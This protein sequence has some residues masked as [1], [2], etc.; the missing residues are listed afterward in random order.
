MGRL[1]CFATNA[2][3]VI[4]VHVLSHRSRRF[5]LANGFAIVVRTLMWIRMI[6][7]AVQIMILVPPMYLTS[8]ILEEQD[9]RDE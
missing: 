1:C 7:P 6:L 4:I 9:V 2:M 3:T 8:L 5:H